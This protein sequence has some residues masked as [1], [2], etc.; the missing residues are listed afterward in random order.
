MDKK[1]SIVVLPILILIL[2][3]G[4]Y[5]RCESVLNTEVVKPLR[6]DAGQ[7]FMYAYNL[8]HKHTYSH[9]VGKPADLESPVKPDA[10]RAPGYPLFL[11][12]FVDGLPNKKMISWILFSQV[13]ISTLTILFTFL[14][15]KRCLPPPWSLG[16]ALLVALSP[17]LIV[18]NSYILTETLF[19]G[20]FAPHQM[21]SS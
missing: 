4:F 12:F 6:A 13:I 19:A 16:T 9:Q 8:R 10:V 7:Y 20:A 1:S 3:L 11:T 2:V 5:L 14:L 17:H 21:V 15:F 18:S